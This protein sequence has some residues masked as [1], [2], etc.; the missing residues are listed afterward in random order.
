MLVLA[1]ADATGG[2]DELEFEG[3][4]GRGIVGSEGLE[5]FILF[6]DSVAL[7]SSFRPGQRMCI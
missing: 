7:P 1:F 5:D 6:V 4:E 2:V 3:S